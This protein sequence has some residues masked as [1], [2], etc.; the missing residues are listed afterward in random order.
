MRNALISL[1]V[2]DQHGQYTNSHNPTSLEL[3]VGAM[4]EYETF[5]FGCVKIR[6]PGGLVDQI[7]AECKAAKSKVSLSGHE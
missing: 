5:Q 4:E 6:L 3:Y 1:N 2:H 7:L